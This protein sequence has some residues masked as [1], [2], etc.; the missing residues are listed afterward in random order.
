MEFQGG[1]VSENGY[2]QQGVTDY[3]WKNPLRVRFFLSNILSDI[4]YIRSRDI[5]EDSQI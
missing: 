2:P 4:E 3:F 1:T 5:I